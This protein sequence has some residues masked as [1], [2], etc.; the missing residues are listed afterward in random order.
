[1]E[2]ELDQIKEGWVRTALAIRRP[3]PPEGPGL[4]RSQASTQPIEVLIA[5]ESSREVLEA[6]THDTAASPT[7]LNDATANDQLENNKKA[8]QQEELISAGESSTVKATVAKAKV[9]PT[10]LGMA[11][12]KEEL[13]AQ[14]PTASK[15][16]TEQED[17]GG[18]RGVRKE[19]QSQ[20]EVS[21]TMAE[22]EEVVRLKSRRRLKSP[23]V[24]VDRAKKY[25]RDT[26]ED[27]E[28]A[29]WRHEKRRESNTKRHRPVR[30]NDIRGRRHSGSRYRSRSPIQRGK[31][32]ARA[33]EP[34]QKKQSSHFYFE[35]VQQ[36]V[37][38]NEVVN[39]YAVIRSSE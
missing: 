8:E 28:D 10:K 11:S 9:H 5:P 31:Q 6:A 39:V 12:T 29:H 13:A 38:V 18:K 15:K 21:K 25:R 3:H 30:D 22:D 33:E 17:G 4:R 19:H 26:S 32:N 1:M 36:L 16:G 37:W 7:L 14:R 35:P 23:E 34:E 24:E 2:K 27:D 20:R